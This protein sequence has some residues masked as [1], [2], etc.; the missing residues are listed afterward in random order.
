[1]S[2]LNGPARD[3]L[4]ASYVLGTLTARARAGVQR[5]LRRDTD[6]TDRVQFW[7]AEFSRLHRGRATVLPPDH[8]WH[9][10]S[11]KTVNKAPPTIEPAAM[12]ARR[13][14]RD[15]ANDAEATPSAATATVNPGFWR[16][17]A[18]A[19][20]LLSM[21]LGGALIQRLVAAPDAVI[22]A[23]APQP[24]LGV[25]AVEGGRWL[26]RVPVDGGFIQV[27]VEGAPKVDRNR[28]P[29]LWWIGG[30]GA[31]R[32]LGLLPMDG[33]VQLESTDLA[34][35]DAPVLAVS[36]E[37]RGGSKTGKPTGP[38]V[39]QFPVIRDL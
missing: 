9:L 10:I 34:P 8:L 4:A 6:L 16:V 29:E 15:A 27:R 11:E 13:H 24:Y 21:V 33:A 5:R 35:S 17:W 36:M 18:V 20:S 7:E 38:V 39:V 26:V 3:Y 22:I 14:R 2:R 25:L 12:L 32:S 37:P 28:S 23:E 19:A 1:M 30:D 31:P